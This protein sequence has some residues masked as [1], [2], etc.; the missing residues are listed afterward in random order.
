MAATPA[1]LPAPN[2]KLAVT[3]V[4]AIPPVP[5]MLQTRAPIGNVS[6]PTVTLF[7]SSPMTPQV[8]GVMFRV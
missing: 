6:G 5:A 8:M 1:A 2:V 4:A 7:E 3:L